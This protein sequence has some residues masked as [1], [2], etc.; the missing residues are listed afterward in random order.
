MAHNPVDFAKGEDPEAERGACLPQ[1]STRGKGSWDVT[2]TPASPGTRLYQAN[3]VHRTCSRTCKIP[4][5]LWGQSSDC[6]PF[7]SPLQVRRARTHSALSGDPGGETKTLPASGVGLL[8]ALE[9]GPAASRRP[10]ALLSLPPRRQ[11]ASPAHS[12]VAHV[13]PAQLLRVVVLHVS[14]LLLA[15]GRSAA[16][17]ARRV[18]HHDVAD[19]LSQPLAALGRQGFPL[20]AGHDGAA[21]FLSRPEA[22]EGEEGPGE[23]RAAARHGRQDVR[24]C[25]GRAAGPG[26]LSAG[27]RWGQWVGGS[28]AG[29]VLPY[30]WE[31]L[32][33][34]G[35]APTGCGMVRPG[36]GGERGACSSSWE[37]VVG[38]GTRAPGGNCGFWKTQCLALS[39]ALS[40]PSVGHWTTHQELSQQEE[41]KPGGP[42][43]SSPFFLQGTEE[44]QGPIFENTSGPK[45][46][47]T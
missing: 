17:A 14:G 22:Q 35:G 25:L 5:F 27:T 19:G 40:L 13:A 9:S 11:P 23:Q 32:L 43:A 16:D 46:D 6:S 29:K 3:P 1:G 38:R 30:A 26:P 39:P 45:P 4:P 10:R 44:T 24:R 20:S 28:P 2:P 21:A 8:A 15:R 42:E 41:R 34:L 18:R 33:F 7:P 36:R 47:V 37:S 12:L 31:G